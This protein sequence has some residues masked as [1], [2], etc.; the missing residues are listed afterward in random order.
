MDSLNKNALDGFLEYA[1]EANTRSTL[2]VE[3]GLKP[4]H[5]RI[6]Y[7][8]AED[9]ILSNKPHESSAQIAGKVMG[10]YHPHGDASVY[11]AAVRMSQDFK[12]RYPLIDFKGNNGSILDPDSYAASRYTK[13]R[14]SELG[15][16]MLAD[17]EK[18]TVPMIPNYNE[19]TVEPVI[20][21]SMIP[22]ILLNGGMGIGV[23][24]SSSLLPHNLIEVVDGIEAYIKNPRITTEELMQYIQGPDFPTGG[25]ITDAFSLKDAYE[26]GKGTIQLRAKYTIKMV[27]GRNTIIITE[28]P[29]LVSIENRIIAPIKQMVVE[30]NYDKIWDIQ[31]ASGEKGL[32]LRIILEKD[33]NPHNVLQ[34]L[35]EKTG[36]EATMKINQTVMLNDGSFVTLGLRGLISHYIKHQHTILINS[37]KFDLAK[38]EARL[39][40]VEGLIIA[41]QNI[42]EVV[43]IIK[44]SA[45]PAAAK[46]ALMSKFSLNEAQALAILDMRLARLTSLELNKLMNEKQELK[47][48]IERLL[49]IIAD[50]L[51]REKILLAFLKK[52][53]TKFGDSRRTSISENKIVEKS[54]HI[55][56]TVDSANRFNSILKDDI[57]TLT[58]GKKGT[59]VGAVVSAFECTTKDTVALLDSNGKVYIATVEDILSE[60]FKPETQIIQILEPKEKDFIIFVTKEG[61]IKKTPN[62]KFR[63]S[64]QLTKVRED[65]KLIGMY[66]ANDTDFIMVLGSEGKCVN[67]PVSDI[68]A[69]GKL[70]YG[71][72]GIATAEVIAATVSSSEDLILTITNENKAKLTKHEDF[73][74]NTKATTGQLITEDCVYI[75]NVGTAQHITLFGEDGRA[76]TIVVG[77]LAIKGKNSVGAKIFNSKLVS[78]VTL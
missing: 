56:L 47:L 41:V 27:N 69:I 42:D 38:A 28:V 43:A 51:E 46:V 15:E 14:L 33:V 8:L 77:S 75:L 36:L 31:N 67:I 2:A 1:L 13:M 39:N 76:A 40:I 64:S 59:N 34:T 29:Y 68:N 23:G 49:K 60:S 19:K 12:L 45:S 53:K 74:I 17:I 30:E 7:S 50:P 6:L 18:N 26:T 54:E 57:A 4:V 73:S 3:D 21:P 58:R 62:V 78:V 25:V 72:K 22:N 16:L 37:S 70:T 20:L 11:D 55:Y 66:Y 61:I 44:G 9:K 10:Y 71:A 48:T 32:E 35:F 24:V 63:K 52:L 5:R 65:D